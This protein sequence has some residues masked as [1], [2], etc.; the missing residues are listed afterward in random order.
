MS[1]QGPRSIPNFGDCAHALT[2]AGATHVSA[3]DRLADGSTDSQEGTQQAQRP[4]RGSQ[5][6][7]NGSR[8]VRCNDP[9]PIWQHSKQK[10]TTGQ[11]ACHSFLFEYFASRHPV[12]AALRLASLGL[13]RGPSRRCERSSYKE[14]QALIWLKPCST[15]LLTTTSLLMEAGGEK[16]LR[17]VTS[18]GL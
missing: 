4:K 15:S 7:A 17:S 18:G 10:W 3:Q 12:Q 13:D 16:P 5:N 8:V 9:R 6:S 14:W 1:Q 11:A 2:Q